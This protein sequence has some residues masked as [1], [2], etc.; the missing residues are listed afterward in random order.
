MIAM[1]KLERIYTVPLG[2]AYDAV[3]RK[4]TPRA[5]KILREFIGRHMKADGERIVL[6]Q[7]LNTHL[8][9]RSIQK[10]PRRVKVRLVKDEGFVRAYLADEKVEE[11]KKEA[12]EKKESKAEAKKEEAPK[13]EKKEAAA[14]HPKPETQNAKPETKPAPKHEAKKAEAGR[15]EQ[16]K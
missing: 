6:S 16:K 10:P 5:V 14:A 11:P 12:K 7:A 2:E 9:E 15:G 8:W 3:R 1:A 13:S 4:R